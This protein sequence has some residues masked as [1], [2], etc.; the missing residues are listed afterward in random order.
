MNL[1]SRV[2]IRPRALLS[3]GAF[4]HVEQTVTAAGVRIT[5]CAEVVT[6][7]DDVEY[8]LPDDAPNADLCALC[9]AHEQQGTSAD[10]D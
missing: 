1:A 4:W 5:S 3:Q 10:V 6:P 8:A 7:D 9:A 2:W